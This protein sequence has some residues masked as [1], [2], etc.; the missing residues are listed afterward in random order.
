MASGQGQVMRKLRMKHQ[1]YSQAGQA[2]RTWNKAGVQSQISAATRRKR[3]PRRWVD[4]PETYQ[5]TIGWHVDK[6]VIW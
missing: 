2:V 6:E 4:Q 1:S 5:K 3:P